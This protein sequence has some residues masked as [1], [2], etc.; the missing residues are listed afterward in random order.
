MLKKGTEP[1]PATY[2]A[3]VCALARLG[4]L[5]A[6]LSLLSAVAGKGIERGVTTYA[7][8]LSSCETLGRW[9]VA[10]DLLQRMQEEG[11]KPTTTCL[12]AALGA[13]VQGGEPERAER[14][15][16]ALCGVCKPDASTFNALVRVYC[17]V[18]GGR[19][20][21]AGCWLV[22]VV[23]PEGCGAWCVFPRCC[24]LLPHHQPSPCLF[25]AFPHTPPQRP[26]PSPD[27]PPTKTQTA[28]QVP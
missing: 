12:N 2:N 21:A 22:A 9:D 5:P 15:F 17:Q 8:L 25:S 20:V 11:L 7:A 28:G 18:R 23:A 19:W 26:P 27:T 3:A 24:L 6:A 14:L 1:M 13:C 4:R 10:V 16:E